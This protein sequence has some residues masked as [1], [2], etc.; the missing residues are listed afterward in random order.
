MPR[1][2]PIDAEWMGRDAQPHKD[3]FGMPASHAGMG[4]ASLV[5]GTCT[6]SYALAR[7]SR[8]GTPTDDTRA[9]MELLHLRLFVAVAEAGS[10]T[11][12]SDIVHLAQPA[13]SRR[14]QE[15]ERE[16]GGPLLERTARGVVLTPLGHSLLEH[17]H[18]ML[19]AHTRFM[20]RAH[21]ALG[22]PTLR[23][24][25]VDYGLP[26]RILALAIARFA[27]EHPDMRVVEVSVAM[28][29]QPALV[30]AGELDLGFAAGGWDFPEGMTAHRLLH[31]PLRGV[32][33]PATHALANAPSVSLD[34][35]SGE[36]L[37]GPPIEQQP[38]FFGQLF[39]QM[40]AAGW[41][42]GRYAATR[43]HADTDELVR[44]GHGFS[45]VPESLLRFVPVGTVIRPLDL[46]AVS[47]SSPVIRLG[48]DWHGVTRSDDDPARL[49]R[50]ARLLALI[51]AARD[52]L[53][54]RPDAAAD[55]MPT[56]AEG[57]PK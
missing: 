16:L 9:R 51:E 12:A 35:L 5:E 44:H 8:S 6:D 19:D 27:T 46:Q 14:M 15:L 56:P 4:G 13:L 24:G 49:A 2:G 57:M 34:A 23:V 3:F 54:A 42:R 28:H 36:T 47:D 21:R 22:A 37:L 11:A 30:E 53:L 1:E 31:D 40:R 32:L 10:I 26:H 45:I 18:Q 43:S 39:E 29:L 52:E 41:R 17:A 48:Y 50:V 20:Q 38:A 33:L 7:A 55:A 25:T